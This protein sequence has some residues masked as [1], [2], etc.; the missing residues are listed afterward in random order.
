MIS[1]DITRDCIFPARWLFTRERR[2]EEV[3]L[4]TRHRKRQFLFHRATRLH[5]T[6]LSLRIQETLSAYLQTDK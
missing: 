4:T 3:A 5:G 6:A 2:E 1:F